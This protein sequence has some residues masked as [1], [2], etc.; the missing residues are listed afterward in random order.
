MSL[1]IM[2]PRML[3]SSG[4]LWKLAGLTLRNRP[5]LQRFWQKRRLITSAFGLAVPGFPDFL[6]LMGDLTINYT[7]ALVQPEA[8]KLNDTIKFVGPAV[9]PRPHD[10]HFPFDQLDERPLIYIS[11]GT[12]INRNPD[13]YRRCIRALGGMDVQVVMSTGRAVSQDD[14]GDIPAN[15]IVRSYVPQLEILQRAA[16]FI[17]HAGMNSVHEGLYHAVPLI[18][19][20]QQ[21]EQRLVANRVVELGA[22]LLLSSRAPSPSAI[23]Q[24]VRRVLHEPQFCQRAAIIGESLRSAGGEVRAADEIL[25]L[26]NRV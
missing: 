24:A 26:V 5:Y 15:F 14:L 22:G 20:P 10:P 17:T 21:T 4:V 8:D 11:L 9:Q 1:L 13:F 23:Q 3:L 18:L 25:A 16:V 7:S 6:N 19:A 12:V 2:R